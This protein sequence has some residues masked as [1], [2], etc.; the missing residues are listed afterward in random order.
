VALSNRAV[1]TAISVTTSATKTLN[2]RVT[3]P[4]V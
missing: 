2:I 4:A 1:E 3:T